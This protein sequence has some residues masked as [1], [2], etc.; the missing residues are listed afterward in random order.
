MIE[1]VD[2]EFFIN[3]IADHRPEYR[4]YN[5]MILGSESEGKI[6]FFVEKSSETMY[7]VLKHMITGE[8]LY[9]KVVPS[10]NDL[11]LR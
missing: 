1:R 6:G 9:R 11:L 4:H 8:I 2:R 10:L 5:V 7:F 3:R